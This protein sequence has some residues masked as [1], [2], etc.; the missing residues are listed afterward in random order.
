MRARPLP[1]VVPTGVLS[2]NTGALGAP[3]ASINAKPDP[4]GGPMKIFLPATTNAPEA[5]YVTVWVDPIRS[6][7]MA[8]RPKRFWWSARR[9]YVRVPKALCEALPA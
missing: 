9:L 4:K 3:G 7:W 2:R 5:L 1:L 6:A 8:N